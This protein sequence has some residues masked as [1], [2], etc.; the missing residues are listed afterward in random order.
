MCSHLI[1]ASLLQMLR[2][3]DSAS[4]RWMVC[5]RACA[6]ASHTATAIMAP[7]RAELE[8]VLHRYETEIKPGVALAAPNGICMMR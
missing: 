2:Q 5:A 7:I 8:Q 6:A 1:A 4:K 3:S